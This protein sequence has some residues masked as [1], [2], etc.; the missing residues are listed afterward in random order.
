MLQ[1]F[2]LFIVSLNSLLESDKVV[3]D[4]AQEDDLPESSFTPKLAQ[5]KAPAEMTLCK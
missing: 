2:L 1:I 5:L 3:S 4:V